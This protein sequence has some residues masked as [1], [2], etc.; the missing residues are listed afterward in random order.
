MIS[1][2]ASRGI[3]TLAALAIALIAGLALSMP[4]QAFAD[5]AP[6]TVSTLDDGD[7]KVIDTT[8]S[9][10]WVKAGKKL[11]QWDGYSKKAFNGTLQPREMMFHYISA[12]DFAKDD[13]AAITNLKSSNPN[14]I[15]PALKAKFGYIK[16]TSK[17]L[18]T[19]TV[20]YTISYTDEN[21][22]AIIENVTETH[23]I[24]KY[25]RPVKTIKVGSKNYTAKFK[26]TPQVNAKSSISGKLTVKPTKGWT[27]KKIRRVDSSM[28][29]GEFVPQ[30]KLKNGS[31]V[32]IKK[33]DT[34]ALEVICY[35]KSGKYYSSVVL[36]PNFTYGII[37]G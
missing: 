22:Q 28:T 29:S 16:Y 14:I 23:K 18:G 12:W 21:G 27:I 11:Y 5:D 33:S 1:R 36:C 32:N 24:V 26:T 25:K 17:K 15:K 7:A 4:A 34:K 13:Y 35:N 31:K 20:T 10:T 9:Y 3:A 6:L 19:A 8:A 30:K 2:T 37:A